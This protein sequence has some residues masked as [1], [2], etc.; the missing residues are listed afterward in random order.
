MVLLNSGQIR[1][2]LRGLT[3]VLSI[4]SGAVLLD[5]QLGQG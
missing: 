1:P 2:L 4:I 3:A 5:V